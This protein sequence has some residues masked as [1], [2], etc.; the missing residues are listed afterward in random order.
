[1]ERRAAH[2][3]AQPMSRSSDKTGLPAAGRCRKWHSSLEG[4]HSVGARRQPLGSFRRPDR[5][6]WANWPVVVSQSPMSSTWRRVSIGT[7]SCGTF[8]S[9]RA[10]NPSLDNIFLQVANDALHFGAQR[11]LEEVE[12]SG[13]YL[14]RRTNTSSSIFAEA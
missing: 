9:A 6:A 8:A 10:G 12:Q 5:A 3:W 14:H 13:E 7:P 1:M 11:S 2:R 4:L